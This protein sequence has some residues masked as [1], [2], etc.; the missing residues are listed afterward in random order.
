MILERTKV[1]SIFMYPK[2]LKYRQA[3]VRLDSDHGTSRKQITSWQIR[4]SG[5]PR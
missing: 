2:D 3:V 4:I 1:R 5:R